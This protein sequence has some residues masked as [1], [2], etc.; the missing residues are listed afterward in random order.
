MADTD[1]KPGRGQCDKKDC[2]DCSIYWNKKAE[3][4]KQAIVRTDKQLIDT[5]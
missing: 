5:L 2:L 3:D 4:R 1:C